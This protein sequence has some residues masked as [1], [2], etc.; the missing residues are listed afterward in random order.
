MQNKIGELGGLPLAG[1]TS[2]ITD[3][4]TRTFTER[5]DELVADDTLTFYRDYPVP[6]LLDFIQT[7]MQAMSNQNETAAEFTEKLQSFHD[8]GKASVL[9][10]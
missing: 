8:E 6:G 3:E 7:H 10:G 1:D 5:F 9:Q 2:A 4:I